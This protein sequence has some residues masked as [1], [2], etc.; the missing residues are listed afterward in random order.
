MLRAFCALA[1]YFGAISPAIAQQA[2]ETPELLDLKA[3][4]SQFVS[5]VVA[6][7]GEGATR[8]GGRVDGYARIDGEG[9]G[10]LDGMSINLHAE[11]VYGNSINRVGSRT[12]LPVNT[13]LN[14]PE[15]DNEAFDLSVNVVQQIGKTRLQFGKIN[16][17]DGA[18]AIPIASGGGK[19][20]FQHIG[21]ASPP[22]LIAS[23]KILGA[24]VSAPAGP[25]VVNVGVWTPDDWTREYGPSAIFDNGV[26]GMVAAV[27][28]TRI[29]GQRS[30]NTFTLFAT[31]RRSRHG[32]FPDITLPEGSAPLIPDKHTGL[33]LRYA[34]QQFLWQDPSDRKRGG[35]F[36][37]HVGVS[38]GSPAVLDWSMTAGIAG[39]VPFDSRPQDRFGVGYFRFSM[40]N[41]IRDGLQPVLPNGD[42]EGAEAYYT[43]QLGRIVRGTLSGQIVNPVL[44]RARH[45]VNINLRLVA[46]F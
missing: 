43:A 42:E 9:A 16:L 28:P 32:Q 17:L 7:E 44:T 15:N 37:G 1:A 21:L 36:F 18:S 14:F 22:G 4:W 8:Y 6:G 46:E 39:S 3:Q 13:A 27:L 26:S 2:D 41:R 23:A 12:L 10:I 31:S 25:F 38:L 5:T 40:A 30:F 35:G 33:H 24:I 20:G 11:F 29:A 45:A 19:E 34:L